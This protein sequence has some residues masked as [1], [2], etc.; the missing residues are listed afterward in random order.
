[1][2]RRWYLYSAL[3]LVSALALCCDRLT[4]AI[5]YV[6]QGAGKA[7]DK[8]PG[9]QAAPWKTI[10]RAGAAQELK[11]GDTVLI[12]AGVYRENVSIAVSGEPG[13][14]V[15]FAAAPRARVVIKGSELV[16]GQ[17][18]PLA[19]V[20][21]LK[22]PYPHAF[23]R[24]WKIK[25]GEEY[26]TDPRFPRAYR[27][28]SKR[29]VSQVFLEDDRPL[30]MIGPDAVY[31]NDKLDSLMTI[32]RGRDDL[33]YNSFFFDPQEQALYVNVAGNPRWYSIEV[34]VRGYLLT[35]SKV[36][37]VA[38]RG[39]EMRHNRQPGGQ[40]AAVSIGGC[41]RVVVEDCKVRFADC[42]GMGLGRSQNCVLRRCDFS[43][44]GC[45][46]LVLGETEDCTVEDCTLFFN[47]YR[48]FCRTWGVAAGMKNI[49]G[50]KRTTV[51]RCE[52]A[53]CTD[54]EG[55]WFDTD[56][57]DIRILDNVVHDNADYGV[58]FEI[59]PGG[60]VIAGNLVYGNHSRGIYVSGSQNTYVVHNTVAE[61]ANGI[62]AMTRGKG[63][64]AR[65]TRV[66]NN[67]LLCNYVTAETIT[68]GADLMLETFADPHQRAEMGSL[69][70]YNVY[71]N[72]CWTPRLAHGWNSGSSLP[73]WQQRFAQDRHS[74]QMVVDYRRT[75]TTFK[76]LTRAG[77][78]VAGPLPDAVL[79]V[80]KPA[81][82]KRVGAE[83]TEWP[84]P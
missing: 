40:W 53:Y 49:P 44:N 60:G 68:R 7:S 14:P 42:T 67:L 78:D 9:T 47:N 45:T 16:R 12:R 61:N 58:Y 55:I 38:I 82:P 64:P 71:A 36:H 17:W 27:H 37:D 41:Q 33:I 46:G 34:G 62:V 1:M 57:E 15:T 59:N 39:L 80:W 79:R 29:W 81:D 63:Q 26:F 70:D 65:N 32:G 73:E 5:Y 4:A 18:I 54:G 77:L 30:Q 23:R 75:G 56:N 19:D 28:K 48:Q 13:R 74:R 50:N 76:L 72:N 51:R 20:K 11:P 21:G 3:L 8:N 6:D 83:R 24:V 31:K 84:K 66:L 10:A 22:E 69:S 43:H 35:A 25:L 52:A 2:F